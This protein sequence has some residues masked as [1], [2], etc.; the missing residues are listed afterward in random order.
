MKMRDNSNNDT[1]SEQMIA[2]LNSSRREG[3]LDLE[4][5]IPCG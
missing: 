3:C 1:A 4:M 2:D 5:V